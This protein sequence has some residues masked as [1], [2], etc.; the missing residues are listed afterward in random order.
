[1]ES[2]PSLGQGAINIMLFMEGLVFTR[3]HVQSLGLEM[4]RC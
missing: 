4:G 3:A 1:M 2:P